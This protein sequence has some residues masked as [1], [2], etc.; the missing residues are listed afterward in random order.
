MTEINFENDKTILDEIG[1]ILDLSKENGID[2]DFFENANIHLD[3]VAEKL[4]ISHLQSALFSHILDSS[5][6]NQG[7]FRQ[8]GSLLSSLKCTKCEYLKYLNEIDELVKMNYVSKLMDKK[9]MSLYH[10]QGYY[11]CFKKKHGDKAH[12]L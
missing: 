3:F 11:L 8:E 12:K 5:L 1:H 6:L 9:A 10:S 2:T 4:H 7:G